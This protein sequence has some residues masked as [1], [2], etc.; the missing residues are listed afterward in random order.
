MFNSQF[1]SRDWLSVAR[2]RFP[3][4]LQLH[5]PD[6][7][8]HVV[9]FYDDDNLLIG[10]LCAASAAALAEGSSVVLLATRLHLRQIDE[11][12]VSFGVDLQRL[13]EAGRYVVSDAAETLSG[14][15]INGSLN[16]A[17]FDRVVGGIM[18]EAVSRSANGFVFG[19]GELVALLCADNNPNAAVRLEQLWNSLARRLRFSLYCAYPMSTMEREVNFDALVRICAEHALTVPAESS[20]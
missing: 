9:Q 5:S 11:Q 7:A 6:A 12:L 2:V 14:L 18:R 15:M 4:L 16:E 3:E 8:Q 20:L 17:A 19:F 10:N 13:A 1:Y